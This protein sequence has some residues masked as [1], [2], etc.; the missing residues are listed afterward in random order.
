MHAAQRKTDIELDEHIAYLYSLGNQLQ[1]SS[2]DL[3]IV[4]KQTAL[5]GMTAKHSIRSTDVLTKL[6]IVCKLSIKSNVHVW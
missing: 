5:V 3:S 6:K 2:K 1:N 4:D